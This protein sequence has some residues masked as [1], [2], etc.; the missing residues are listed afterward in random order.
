[1]QLKCS[2]F[3]FDYLILHK[4]VSLKHL[5]IGGVEN[6]FIFVEC[7]FFP[8]LLKELFLGFTFLGI[9][10]MRKDV[11]CLYNLFSLYLFLENC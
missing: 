3:K 4:D 1:M 11:K 6:S 8:S 2:M 7:F 5:F 10:L 9:F